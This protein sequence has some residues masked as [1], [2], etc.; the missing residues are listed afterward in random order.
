M[1]TWPPLLQQAYSY[2]VVGSGAVEGWG[3]AGLVVEHWGCGYSWAPSV[4]VGRD[5]ASG[6]GSRGGPRAEAV[7]AACMQL[8]AVE[9]LLWENSLNSL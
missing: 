6:P 3:T 2:R 9:W 5:A 4:A 8:G 1:R 7:E